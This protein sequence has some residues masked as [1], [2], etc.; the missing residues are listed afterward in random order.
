MSKRKHAIRLSVDP[1][2]SGSSAQR[3]KTLPEVLR[4]VSQNVEGQG[5]PE[6]SGAGERSRIAL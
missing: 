5:R 3:S 1:V 2:D 4:S 6:G